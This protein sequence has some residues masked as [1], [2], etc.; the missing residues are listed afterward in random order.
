M[1]RNIIDEA[2][3]GNY[4]WFILVTNIG[5]LGMNIAAVVVAIKALRR[6]DK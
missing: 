2:F 4:S 6:K 3:R 1:F 5:Q